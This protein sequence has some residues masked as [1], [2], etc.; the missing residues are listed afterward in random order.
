MANV[1]KTE[2]YESDLERLIRIA[3]SENKNG[4]I[5]VAQAIDLIQ[6]KLTGPGRLYHWTPL[7]TEGVW[8]LRVPMESE[9]ANARIKTGGEEIVHICKPLKFLDA[10]ENKQRQRSSDYV[11]YVRDADGVKTEEE[12]Y[13]CVNCTKETP[14]SIAKKGRIQ[15]ALH[16]MK[17]GG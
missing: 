13:H 2:Q 1:E 7:G 3:R 14:L 12:T 17:S 6:Q 11:G 4:T 9:S 8:Y 10:I 16:K 5:R 15:M